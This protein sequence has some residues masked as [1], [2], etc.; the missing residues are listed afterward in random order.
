MLHRQ[1]F[2]QV[3]HIL[4]NASTDIANRVAKVGNMEVAVGDVVA[5]AEEEAEEVDA[6][7]TVAGG[8]PLGLVQAMW[9][10]SS[11]APVVS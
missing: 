11:G 7:L 10:T 2:V 1:K 9:Q 8:P 6:V 5:L 4:A 3:V